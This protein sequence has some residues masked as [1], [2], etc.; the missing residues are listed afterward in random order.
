[1]KAE[2]EK[3]LQELNEQVEFL[4]KKLSKSNERILAL[5]NELA[6][7]TAVR[8]LK[9][10]YLDIDKF[11]NPCTPDKCSLCDICLDSMKSKCI[12]YNKYLIVKN[13]FDKLNND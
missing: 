12:S 11:E 4:S 13:Y 9:R 10:E 5:E 2:C 6:F 3:S 7:Q 1:M 8:Q